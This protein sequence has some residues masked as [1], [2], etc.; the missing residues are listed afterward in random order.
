[1][2]P[3]EKLLQ[4]GSSIRWEIFLKPKKK[5][6]VNSASLRALLIFL[7]KSENLNEVF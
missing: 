6:C 5:L 7:L 4:L 1:M 3:T 2:N